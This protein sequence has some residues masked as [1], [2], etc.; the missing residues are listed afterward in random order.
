MSG[1]GRR[2]PGGGSQAVVAKVTGL[3]P[4]QVRASTITCWEADSV[5]A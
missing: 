3:K 4:E 5:A 2:V 1:S